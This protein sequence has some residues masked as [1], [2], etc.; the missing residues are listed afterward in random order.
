MLIFIKRKITLQN[1]C[2]DVDDLF[3]SIEIE[4]EEYKYITGDDLRN[5][6]IEYT[7]QN[8]KLVQVT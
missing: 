2:E 5:C 1:D 6:V 7:Q 8:R 3:D 4:F